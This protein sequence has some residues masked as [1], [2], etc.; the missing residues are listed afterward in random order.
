MSDSKGFLFV[1]VHKKAG[2]ALVRPGEVRSGEQG[3]TTGVMLESP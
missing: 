1:A 3:W 2:L